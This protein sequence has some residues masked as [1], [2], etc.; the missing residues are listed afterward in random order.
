MPGFQSLDQVDIDGKR[1][2]IRVD[3]NAPVHDGK[4]TDDTRIRAIMCRQCSK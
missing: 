1:V 4:V 3:I 2:L